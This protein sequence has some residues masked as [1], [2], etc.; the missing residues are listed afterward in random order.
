MFH[1]QKMIGVVAAAALWVAM[2]TVHAEAPTAAQLQALSD[3][4]EQLRQALEDTRLM[5]M[6]A[7]QDIANLRATTDPQSL[8]QAK[9]WAAERDALRREQTALTREQQRLAQDRQGLS[10]A[11]R[12]ESERVEAG[13]PPLAVTDTAPASTGP[14]YRYDSSRS[15]NSGYYG[16]N[17]GYP[18]GYGFPYYGGFPYF[19][20][21]LPRSSPAFIHYRDD[22]PL[23]NGFP[24]RYGPD[25]D[26]NHG[27]IFERSGSP[28]SSSRFSDGNF[29]A[30]FNSNP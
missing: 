26:R 11:V 17:Y 16:D 29:N 6:Q 22:V 12:T 19:G 18:Y 3:E 13:N 8:D 10:R 4:V 1:T 5:L 15:I 9:K 2:P 27:I 25:Y 24:A 7:K 20:G 14:L 30:R 28:G 23:N 21:F